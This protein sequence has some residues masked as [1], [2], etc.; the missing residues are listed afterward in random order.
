M[1]GTN[2]INVAAGPND[3]IKPRNLRLN[4][5]GSGTNGIKFLSGKDLQVENL[6]ISDFTQNGIDISASADASVHVIHTSI[7]NIGQVGIH[8][9][10]SAGTTQVNIS[11]SQV[12]STNTGVEATDGCKVVL[13]SLVDNASA[14]GVLADASSGEAQVFISNSDL[15]FNGTAIQSGPGNAQVSVFHSR[16][17]FNGTK[18]TQAGGAISVDDIESPPSDN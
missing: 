1:A 2:A 4:G 11:N 6:F 18:F 10:N 7:K 15:S 17:A 12:S 5:I 13:A 14:A 8:A 3:V 9:A 16:L